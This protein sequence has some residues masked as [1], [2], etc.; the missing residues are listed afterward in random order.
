M[1]D[2]VYLALVFGFFALAIGC[3]AGCERL[4]GRAR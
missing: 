2:L 4:M 1:G 3:V